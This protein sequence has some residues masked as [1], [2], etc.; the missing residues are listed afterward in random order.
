MTLKELLEKAK[1]MRK[2]LAEAETKFYSLKGAY[3]SLQKEIQ[4]AKG[5]YEE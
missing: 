1:E 3:Y 5:K 4:N 2:E